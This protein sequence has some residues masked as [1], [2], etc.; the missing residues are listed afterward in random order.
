MKRTTTTLLSIVFTVLVTMSSFAS[1]PGKSPQVKLLPAEDGM[2]KVL[3]VNGHEKKVNVKI[4]GQEGLLIND[5]V[6]LSS[7]DK[8]F[9]RLYNLKNLEAGE[10]RIEISDASTSISYRVTYQN[11]QTVWAQYW[12]GMLPANEGLASN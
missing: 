10:Y 7:G 5:K 6:K 3:Y 8:G 4:F 9:V 1:D 11:N 2:I 12:D